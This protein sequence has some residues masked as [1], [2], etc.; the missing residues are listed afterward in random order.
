MSGQEGIPGGD[1]GVAVLAAEVTEFLHGEHGA[2]EFRRPQR[3]SVPAGG[4][5]D[6][7][8]QGVDAVDV[9]PD[10]PVAG[11]FEEV[12]AE[13][14]DGGVGPVEAEIRVGDFVVDGEVLGR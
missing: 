1:P 2:A 10:Q 3:Q 12:A 13:R 8:R 11:P 9:E 14:G 4:G 6:G 7:L 5:G